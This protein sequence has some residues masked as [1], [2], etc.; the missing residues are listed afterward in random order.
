MH[1]VASKG[2]DMADSRRWVTTSALSTLSLCAVASVSVLIANSMPLVD[3]STA[4]NVP[5]ISAVEPESVRDDGIDDG[6][7]DGT[8]AALGGLPPAAPPPLVTQPPEQQPLENPPP[9]QQLLPSASPVTPASP[10]SIASVVTPASP[11]SIVS[12]ASVGL[13]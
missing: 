12:P 4:V 7:D 10:T 8:G 1:Y 9:V 2:W 3:A 11:T 5:P 6:I 13:D